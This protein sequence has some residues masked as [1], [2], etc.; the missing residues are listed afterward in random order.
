MKKKFVMALLTGLVV[1]QLAGCGNTATEGNKTEVS[2]ENE[3][4]EVQISL[5]EIN[6]DEYV[7]LGE[8]KGLEVEATLIEIT[9]AEIET[10]IEEY[11]QG[12][13]QLQEVTDRNMVQEGDIA[14]IDY[15]GKKDGVAFDGGSDTGYDLTIGSGSFI[16]GFEEGL[17][18]VEVGETV[19]LNLTF[20]EN[21]H[22]DSLAGAE[23]VFTVT[24]NSISKMEAPEV[25]DEYVQS[26]EVEGVTTVEGWRQ[27]IKDALETTARDE[28]KYEVQ[29]QLL[30]KIMENATVKEA[31]EA[32]QMKYKNVTNSQMEYQAAYYGIDLESFIEMAYGLD[33]ET[34]DA[35]ITAAAAESAKLALICKKIGDIEGLDI[36]DEELEASIE[37]NY[38]SWGYASVEECKAN[39][40]EESYRDD[41][42]ID[43]VL[44]LLMEYAV[45]TE[46]VDEQETSK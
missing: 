4:E 31:P 9:D 46:P 42:L 30:E 11:R 41:L 40:D 26:L 18:G 7:T 6:V 19:D 28:Y 8:Y 12:N 3:T 2:S 33:M 22:E 34:Y 27:Y 35:T 13:A 36:T 44:E 21:Y 15:V 25:T 32:L 45:I 23:V 17:I 24:V 5:S 37:A 38:L 14:N 39:M 29:L 43:E 10:V 1:F 16:A 20:P